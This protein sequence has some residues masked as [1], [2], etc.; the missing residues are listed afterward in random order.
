MLARAPAFGDNT[1]MLPQ[2]DFADAHRRHWK[3]AELLFEHERWA[4][5]DHLYGFSAECGLK[6]IMLKTLGVRIDRG[7]RKHVDQLWPK[8]C[9]LIETRGQT[10]YLVDG[11][12]FS[13]WSIDDRYA[14]GRHVDKAK[15]ER[16]RKGAEKVRL[17]LENATADGRS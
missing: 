1:P 4:N 9:A 8:Y 15:S 16:H 5:A 11:C 3:D 10:R 7:Y 6:A 17:M 12:P 13:D 2:A 14:P